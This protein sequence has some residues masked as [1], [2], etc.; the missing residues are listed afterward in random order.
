MALSRLFA[1]VLF[2]AAASLGVAHAAGISFGALVDQL[3]MK[4]FTKLQVEES[5]KKVKGSEVT[6]SA[7]VVEVKG[8]KHS[9]KVYL[10]DRSRKNYKGY[11]I[12]LATRDVDRAAKLRRG[13]RIRFTGSLDDYDEH[14]NGSTTIGLK[15]GRIL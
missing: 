2:T 13:Q 5:W 15:D 10:I 8:G 1:V 9:A 7:D 4:R 11:N 6:W 14:N 3:D 12:T